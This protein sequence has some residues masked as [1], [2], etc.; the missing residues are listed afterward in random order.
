MN[1]SN[2]GK[3]PTKGTGADH[4]QS[5]SGHA[6][7]HSAKKSIPKPRVSAA[8]APSEPAI[9]VDETVDAVLEDREEKDEKV[10]P[11]STSAPYDVRVAIVGNVDSGK[12]TLIG[13]LTGGDL[14]NGR[15]SARS[16]IFVHRHEGETGRTS[17]ISQHIMGFSE[18][19]K[20][21]HQ[22]IPASATS[23]S[24]NKAWRDVVKK[25]RSVL[26]LIDLAGHERY[27]KTTIA[28]LTG[29]F[30]D[31]AVVV[32]GANMGITKMTKEHLGV[33]IALDIPVMCVITK[34]DMCPENVLAQ[35][36]K[37]LYRILQ[38]Q[39][40]AKR[41]FEV[42]NSA[43]VGTLINNLSAKICPVF[44]ISCVTGD[45]LPLLYEYLARLRPLNQ[46]WIEEQAKESGVEFDIDNTFLV[47]GVGLVLSG[48]VARGVLHQNSILLLGPFGS[49]G[50]FKKVQVR[51]IHFKRAPTESCAAGASCAAALRPLSRKD[52]LRRI[53]IR[54]GMVLVDP[55]LNPR[56]AARFEAQ[57][58]VLHHPTTI[59][60][61]YQA[62][63]HCGII[64]QTAAIT[65]MDNEFLRTG[66]K[67]IVEFTFVI[68][69]EYI[70]EGTV[71]I[72]REG[73]TKG[74]GRVTRVL[75]DDHVL[76]ASVTSGP[77]QPASSVSVS[78]PGS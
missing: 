31:F 67:A 14:D 3:G 33:V 29:C 20:A 7:K 37:Q 32:V 39:G 65:R 27:L 13:V 45:G 72:F 25:S 46:R 59:K 73:N 10:E 9:V 41:P 24:K 28:G 48:T 21:V 52:Q 15:G 69:P 42:R 38:S 47:T 26:T 43:D 18:D 77:A 75:Y 8:P 1:I 36:K 49:A 23:A 11:S 2:K 68:R 71:L 61:H 51:T 55:S 44:L 53:D 70:K 34:I 63:I 40:A 4:D 76:S 60:M 22:P 74:V 62:V 66:D 16:R 54:R 30:P 12:S 19:N 35:T 17:C 64:R 57:V 50:E 5:K 58:L 56:A 78:A 6:G